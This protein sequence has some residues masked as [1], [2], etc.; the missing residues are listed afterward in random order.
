LTIADEELTTL[1]DVVCDC[2]RNVTEA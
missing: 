2:I 1:L